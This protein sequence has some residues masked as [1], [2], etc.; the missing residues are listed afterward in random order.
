MVHQRLATSIRGAYTTQHVAAV[1]L[2]RAQ[3]DKLDVY[4]TLHFHHDGRCH[5]CKTQLENIWSHFSAADMV[6]VGL[7]LTFNHPLPNLMTALASSADLLPY[8]H[9]SC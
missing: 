7:T 2:R 8:V 5:E 3:H 9:P 1:A 4:A 6:Y